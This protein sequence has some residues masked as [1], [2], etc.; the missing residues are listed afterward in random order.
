MRKI[1]EYKIVQGSTVEIM[2]KIVTDEISNGWEL[3]G[4]PFIDTLKFNGYS[5]AMVKYEE[6]TIKQVL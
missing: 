6:E 1:I 2:N 4:F 3:Y 5:Q